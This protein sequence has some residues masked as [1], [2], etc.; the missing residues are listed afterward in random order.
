MT[1]RIALCVVSS[2][3]MVLDGGMETPTFL[4]DTVPCGLNWLTP[5]GG[6]SEPH[7]GNTHPPTIA[8]EAS[9]FEEGRHIE[10]DTA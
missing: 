2:S 7:E 1:R 4:R 6:A 5:V 10:F 3:G 9:T 8:F